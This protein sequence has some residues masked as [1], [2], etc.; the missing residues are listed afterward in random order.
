MLAVSIKDGGGCSLHC[1]LQPAEM[2]R[3]GLLLALLALLGLGYAGLLAGVPLGQLGVVSVALQRGG[4]PGQEG[5]D[6]VR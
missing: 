3:V 4:E 2:S 5:P 1:P 6:A